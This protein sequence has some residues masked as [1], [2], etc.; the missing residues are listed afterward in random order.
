MFILTK[1]AIRFLTHPL[2]LINFYILTAESN[3]YILYLIF[4]LEKEKQLV[5]SEVDEARL[6]TEQAN[7]AKVIRLV[8]YCVIKFDFCILNE[9]IF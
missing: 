5:K 1:C 3:W 6:H 8:K 7:K 2:L 9:E 4:R